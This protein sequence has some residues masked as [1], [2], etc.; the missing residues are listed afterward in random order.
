MQI[1][2]KFRKRSRT[3]KIFVI[4]VLSFFLIN[5]IVFYIQPFS[6]ESIYE[7][8]TTGYFKFITSVLNVFLGFAPF[9]IGDILY[10]LVGLYLIVRIIHF[11]I[12]LLFRRFNKLIPISLKIIGTLLAIWMIL[13][14]QWNWNYLQPPLEKKLNLESTDY[15]VEELADFTKQLIVKTIKTKNNS[16]FKVFTKNT[17]SIIDI[18]IL[19]YKELAKEDDFFIYENPSIKYSLF[20]SILPYVGISG[21]Y[22]PFTAEAQ[23]TKGIPIIQLPFVINH[24]ISHQLG[25]ASE[26]EAN[27]IGYLA[28]VNNPL[29]TIQYS[30]NLNLLMYCL[31]DLRMHDYKEYDKIIASIPNGIKD[32]INEISVFWKSYR[33]EYRKYFDSGYDTYLKNNNQKDGLASYNKVVS[34]AIFY[35]RKKSTHESN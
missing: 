31:S 10:I 9:S 29:N 32:D 4:S 19:G 34:L 33:N 6:P 26:A 5:N 1:F 30:G 12:A 35:N 13:V 14:T 20:S 11:I 17:N 7:H 18:S 16:N 21:Y 25:I 27:F 28:T 23:I 24:E 3:Y 2:P 22:N 8:Y 15:N